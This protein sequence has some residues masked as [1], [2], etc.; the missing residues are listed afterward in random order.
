MTEPA[1]F[2]V[3]AEGVHL[4]GTT[5]VLRPGDLLTPERPSNYREDTALSHVYVTETLHAAAWGAQLAHGDGEPRIYVVEPTGELED[6]P[7]VT[8]KRFPGNPTRSYRT[9][10][11]VRVVRELEDWPRHSPESV[12]AMQEGLA[13]LRRKGEDVII[14]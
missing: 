8:D 12:A 3:F 11:P 9:R 1:P 14:D 6:D 4:H 10:E 2:E 5:A 7:N 13:E